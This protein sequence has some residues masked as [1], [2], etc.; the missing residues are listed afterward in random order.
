MR[1]T[2]PFNTSRVQVKV[3]ALPVQPAVLNPLHWSPEVKCVQS[4]ANI[5]ESDVATS[6]HFF[7]SHT[8]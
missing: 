2:E 3:L 4:G 1:D 5:D 6:T 8:G 7:S